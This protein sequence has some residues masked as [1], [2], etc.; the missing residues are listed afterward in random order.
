MD[1]SSGGKRL[2]KRNRYNELALLRN[3][4]APH[5]YVPEARYE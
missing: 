2:E 5:P 1:P 4:V 3:A